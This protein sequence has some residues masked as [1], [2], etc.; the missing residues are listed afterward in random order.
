MDGMRCEVDGKTGLPITGE[1]ASA[2]PGAGVEKAG[3]FDEG[4][5]V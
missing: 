4:D 1:K 3:R 2:G 5:E